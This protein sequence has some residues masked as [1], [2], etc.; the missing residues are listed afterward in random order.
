MCF[1]GCILLWPFL[2]DIPCIFCLLIYAD[3]AALGFSF[4][5]LFPNSLV[6][7]FNIVRE[8]VFPSCS[9]I[10]SLHLCTLQLPCSK[11]VCCLHLLIWLM[12][13]S[14]WERF[15]S[16]DPIPNNQ[17]LCLKQQFTSAEN[18]SLQKSS[19]NVFQVGYTSKK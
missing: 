3:T 6:I 14:K 10:S 2:L 19:W 4:L 9:L 17:Q 16:M 15:M 11:T 8:S 18:I 12:A 7:S 5:A 1:W 13:V